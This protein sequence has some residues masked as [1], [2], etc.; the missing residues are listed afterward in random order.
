MIP[1]IGTM[2]GIIP[3]FLLT[4][5]AGDTFSAWG[6]LIYGFTIVGISDNVIR[7][8]ALKRLDDVHPLITLIGVIIVVPLFGFFCL[9]FGPILISLLIFL[10]LVYRNNKIV[11]FSISYLFRFI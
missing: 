2:I 11:N 8:Y 6:I 5:S 4:L 3:V 1:V 10:V 7:L 9:I